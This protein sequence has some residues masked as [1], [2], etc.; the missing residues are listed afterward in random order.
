M[1]KEE[2]GSFYMYIFNIMLYE[3]AFALNANFEAVLVLTFVRIRF[4]INKLD[5]RF[6]YKLN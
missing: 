5:W 3:I 6:A 2:I 1:R 4:E